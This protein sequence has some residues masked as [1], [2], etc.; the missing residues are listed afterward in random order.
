MFEFFWKQKTELVAR[1]AL[2]LPH[3]NG[4]WSIPCVET[5]AKLLALK[6]VWGL[7]DDV[8]CSGRALAL[9]WLWHLRRVLVPQGLENSVLRQRLLYCTTP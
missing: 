2:R 3:D 9:Y 4:G 8:V 5:F 1:P 6:C 7:L